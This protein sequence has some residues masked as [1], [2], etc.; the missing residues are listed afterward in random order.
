M[1]GASSL[2]AAAKVSPLVI[3]LTVV[4]FGTSAPE[5]AVS[6]QACQTG[7][8][9]LAIGNAVGS[10]ISNILLIL[11]F[12][13]IFFPLSVHA[14]LF[15]L[16]FPV[17]I[18]AAIALWVLGRDNTLDLR[19]GALLTAAM[20]GYFVWTIL[21][22]R[23]ESRLLAA[24][25]ADVVPPGDP[26]SLRSI[27]ISCLQVLGGLALLVA[28]S[29]WLVDG[30][31]RL[32]L[33]F[34]VSELVIGLTVIAIG[35]SM[36][37]LVTSIVAALRGHRDLAVGNVV[38]SNILN[39]LAVLGISALTSPHGINVAPR[40]LAFDIPVMIAVSL[41]C[42]PVFMSGLSITRTEGA[43]MFAMFIGYTSFLVYAAMHAIVPTTTTALLFSA[44]L[45]AASAL[46]ALV[47]VARRRNSSQ[48]Q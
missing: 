43:V 23:R 9:D 44:P 37:E 4:A 36:P 21:Q 6:V 40:A 7:K 17:M 31:V 48:Q 15:K 26:T 25:F 28:G 14:R 27:V 46:V 8:T 16:D 1:R 34:G 12:S 38:G 41:A 33:L 19:D 39:I 47:G 20:V 13:A 29:N 2:A 42:L 24:E 18:V 11:G 32:A 30:C 5:L 35:T 22:G 3:G 45:L 10:N